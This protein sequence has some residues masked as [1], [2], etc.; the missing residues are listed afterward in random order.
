M[1]YLLLTCLLFAGMGASAQTSIWNSNTMQ[2]KSDTVSAMEDMTGATP[3]VFNSDNTT[4]LVP[5][6]NGFN[7]HY[8]LDVFSQFSVSRWG[9]L[10]FGNITSISGTGQDSAIIPFTAYVIF[11]NVSWKMQGTAPY[12]VFKIE[13]NG[14][15]PATGQAI[16]FQLLLHETNGRIQMLYSGNNDFTNSSNPY[17]IVL[18]HTILG[19][20]LFTTVDMRSAQP[21]VVQYK[22]ITGYAFQVEVPNYEKIQA[23]QRLTFQ[24]DTTRPAT[25]SILFQNVLPGCMN[26][27]PSYNFA[28]ASMFA[29]AKQKK[30]LTWEP[31]GLVPAGQS[32]YDS[33]LW[34]D[35]TYRYGGISTN[36]FYISDSVTQTRTTP[37]PLINGIKTIPGDF[38]SITALLEAAKCS[39]VGPNLVIELQSNYSYS[40]EP[41]TVHFKGRLRSPGLQSIIIRPAAG[42]ALVL[43][44]PSNRPMF[45]IDSLSKVIFDGRQGGIGTSAS[46]TIR[47]TSSY[48]SVIYTNAA[49]SGV[50]RYV[51]FEGNSENNFGMLLITDRDTFYSARKLPVSFMKVDHCKF[52]PQSGTI[53]THLVAESTINLLIEHNE[54]YR[55]RREVV[56]IDWSWAPVF[57]ENRIYQPDSVYMNGE[58]M[59]LVQNSGNALVEGNKFGGSSPV[60]GVGNMRVAGFSTLKILESV[61]GMTAR[62]NEFGNIWSDA[63]SL[64]MISADGGGTIVGNRI[65]TA[66][67]TRSVVGAYNLWVIMG[68]FG[69]ARIDSNFISGIACTQQM[70]GISAGFLTLNGPS[71]TVS[72]NDVGG[73]ENPMHNYSIGLVEGIHADKSNMIVHH[74]TV[75]GFTSLG[76]DAYGINGNLGYAGSEYGPVFYDN[77]SVHHIRAKRILYGIGL[78]IN[79]NGYSRVA[80]N[81]VYALDGFGS[82]SGVPA[83]TTGI[84]IKNNANAIV[85]G[86]STLLEVSNNF[87]HSLQHSINTRSYFYDIKG[88][89]V[90]ATRKAQVFNN[91]VRLGYTMQGDLLDSYE[92]KATGM[93]VTALDME[94]EHNSIY[95]G[96]R[97]GNALQLAPINTSNFIRKTAVL[98]NNILQVEQI[99]PAAFSAVPVYMQYANISNN[100]IVAS[101][102]NLWFSASDP[103]VTSKLATWRAACKCDSTTVI[104]D[105]KFVNPT[106]DSSVMNMHLQAGS[107]ADSTGTASFLNISYDRDSLLRSAYS[108]V[109]KGAYAATPCAGS[110]LITVELNVTGESVFKC[111]NSSVNLQATVNG[112]PTSM[113]W[114]YNLQDIPGAT[115]LSLTAVK[116]GLYRLVAKGACQQVATKGVWVLDTILVKPFISR[117]P[118]AIVCEGTPVTLTAVQSPA[119]SSCTYT[120]SNGATGKTIVVTTPG[121]YLVTATNPALCPVVSD[122]LKLVMNPRPATPVATSGSNTNI[123]AGTVQLTS[124]AASGNQWYRN[125]IAISG[126]TAITYNPTQTGIYA[127]RTTQGSCTSDTSNTIN[128][129]GG[130]PSAVTISASPSATVCAGSTITLTAT[131]AGCTGCTYSWNGGTPGTN[132][133]F[134]ATATGR[135]KVT[136]NNGCGSKTDSIDLVFKP[137]PVVTLN[138]G[139][140]S[141]CPGFSLTMEASGASTYTWSP[142]SGLFISGNQATASPAAT[143]TYTVTGTTNGCSSSRN[144]TI[145]VKPNVVPTITTSYTGCPSTTLQFSASTTNAGSGIPSWFVNG[146]FR[147]MAPTYTLT[148]A[149]NGMQVYA[150]IFS[151]AACANPQS[152]NSSTTTINC[153]STTALNVIDGL[154]LLTA[155]PNPSSGLVHLQ[156]K[157]STARKVSVEIWDASGKK[158]ATMPAKIISGS[159]NWPIQLGAYSSGT[160]FLKVV[161]GNGYR[162]IPVIIKR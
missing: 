24:P 149:A 135:Y 124:S 134:V 158:L 119:C 93:L 92:S 40:L 5:F 89:S 126:A 147:S 79:Y 117:S 39:L 128:V 157:L 47:Q 152:V 99:A 3:F 97:G 33:T 123:C 53:Y 36:G 144:V 64:E 140:S 62:N 34:G 29:L 17:H 41:Y 44:G 75:R 46:M 104:A 51:R 127:V 18:R 82:A 94:L 71:S 86:D 54:F 145:T 108:P 106:G 131:S 129:T 139:D 12:R 21:P 66:D 112:T 76:G 72:Y 100:V 2:F 55:F 59:V 8:G 30:D 80:N 132:N 160:Y 118:S 43:E 56:R 98:A 35:T 1:R 81:T 15:F 48:P 109:D 69:P 114:Q 143:T 19:S 49:D 70:I 77:N 10:K 111:E 78:D 105:P 95:I 87:V 88:I 116:P 150:Q 153:I 155:G 107:A 137:I 31:Q 83:L 45:W 146:V 96:G 11:N 154:E 120:W 85:P 67:S 9:F 115:G 136:V 122:T 65:G 14:Y 4:T 52:G 7:F 159:V 58:R 42:A 101:N 151:N 138:I 61:G 28:V 13:W 133:S 121:N 125:S 57:R 27:Y 113:N 32:Y 156:L 91:V 63:I 90:V 161:A 22:V 141:V 74:N 23:N 16:R 38:P 148:G 73:S 142:T 68:W 6:G 37:S 84:H 20:K 60:W 162:V 110:A 103:N 102:H 130:I 25:P 50:V 26:V